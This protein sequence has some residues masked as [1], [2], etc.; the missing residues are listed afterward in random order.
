MSD[1]KSGILGIPKTVSLVIVYMRSFQ[2][3]VVASLRSESSYIFDQHVP[4]SL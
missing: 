2:R 1:F 3:Q 4:A